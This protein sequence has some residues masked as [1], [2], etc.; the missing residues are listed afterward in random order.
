MWLSSHF[1]PRSMAL[2][3]SGRS[4]SGSFGSASMSVMM[5]SDVTAEWKASWAPGG[6]AYMFKPFV[7][8]GLPQDPSGRW[9]ARRNLMPRLMADLISSGFGGVIGLGLGPW[10]AS[11]ERW[12][13]LPVV[14]ASDDS[15]VAAGLE[16]AAC[17]F[18]G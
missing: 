5:T 7:C 8:S 10:V 12:G 16:S 6:G 13:D 4:F 14:L 3:I 9:S 11:G 15:L 17:D 1:A 2:S 18:V